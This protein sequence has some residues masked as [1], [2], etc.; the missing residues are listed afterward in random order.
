MMPHDIADHIVPTQ[1]LNS[2]QIANIYTYIYATDSSKKPSLEFNVEPRVPL[3]PLDPK[4]RPQRYGVVHPNH[5][6]L[7]SQ[8]YGPDLSESTEETNANGGRGGYVRIQYVF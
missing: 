4:K 7:E 5:T 2:E 1:I 3:T 6:D 8:R